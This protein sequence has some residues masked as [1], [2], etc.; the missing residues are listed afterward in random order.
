M[1]ENQIGKAWFRIHSVIRGTELGLGTGLLT[2]WKVFLDRIC[3]SSKPEAY[4]LVCCKDEQFGNP[5]RFIAAH[6]TPAGNIKRSLQTSHSFWF[7]PEQQNLW[8]LTPPSSSLSGPAVSWVVFWDLP[9]GLDCPPEY[10]SVPDAS[11]I[12]PCGFLI[13]C[14]WEQLCPKI[15]SLAESS[16][17]S[18][19]VWPLLW[20]EE[21]RTFL[22]VVVTSDLGRNSCLDLSILQPVTVSGFLFHGLLPLNTTLLSR[23]LSHI[24]AGIEPEDN[25]LWSHNCPSHVFRI[26]PWGLERVRVPQL[27][28]SGYTCTCLHLHRERQKNREWERVFQFTVAG[29]W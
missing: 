24:L 9:E 1:D 16:P 28:G 10:V 13:F 3:L 19:T 2:P 23:R 25:P 22:P 8:N 18:Y 11:V 17:Q 5:C 14:A 4:F 12:L 7:D 21:Q 6:G 20:A 27:S 15:I 26:G 29:L